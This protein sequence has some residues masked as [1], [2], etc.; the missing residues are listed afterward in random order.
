MGQ[1]GSA[2]FEKCENKQKNKGLA[3]KP[4]VG[5]SG[6]TNNF[7]DLKGIT[8]RYSGGVAQKNLYL[9]PSTS[10]LRCIPSIALLREGLTSPHSLVDH[11]VT[12][13]YS[14]TIVFNCVN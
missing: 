14:Q 6:G 7:Y 11:Y 10:L 4:T 5:V 1:G 2:A 9:R 12:F 8:K 3:R 13:F